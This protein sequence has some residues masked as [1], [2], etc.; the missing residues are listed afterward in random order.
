MSESSAI[1]KHDFSKSAAKTTVGIR[2]LGDKSGKFNYSEEI[3]TNGTHIINT[4]NESKTITQTN[5]VEIN[6]S[7]RIQF[8][9]GND[10]KFTSSLDEG[11]Y[12]SRTRIIGNSAVVAQGLHSA[13]DKLKATLVAAR[14]GFNDDRN[15]TPATSNPS[16]GSIPPSVKNNIS[17]LKADS[18]TGDD[19]PL[20][21]GGGNIF[22]SMVSEVQNEISSYTKIAKK[23]SA[24]SIKEQ[25]A[26]ALKNIS[27]KT[28]KMLEL[29]Q[30]LPDG[31]TKTKILEDYKK[32]DTNA[33]F[34]NPS[35]ESKEK[36]SKYNADE[37][38]AEAAKIVPQIIELEKQNC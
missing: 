15:D 33:I 16:L 30:S 6:G 24:D 22:M 1:T 37:Y 9:S 12:G 28:K 35:S 23:F 17:S 5:K 19:E 3:Y 34:R 7:N 27:E 4:E 20:T 29:I 31:P 38:E 32:G 2:S 18:A 36:K 10:S 8:T 26:L 14:S 11:V 21:S 13:A 25:A